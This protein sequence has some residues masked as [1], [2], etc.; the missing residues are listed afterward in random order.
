MPCEP[1]DEERQPGFF[2]GVT[3]IKKD[4]LEPTSPAPG[5][6]PG[7]PRASPHG[8]NGP[9]SDMVPSDCPVCGTLQGVET[10]F[11]KHGSSY[12]DR[13]LPEAAARL[14]IV[15]SLD[16]GDPEKRHVRR[17]P[18]CGALFSYLLAYDYYIDGS[19]D[20]ETLTRLSADGTAAFRRGEAL[21]LEAV[22]AEI[23]R[24]ESEAGRLGDYIDRGHP[25]PSEM[26]EAMT[27]MEESRAAAAAARKRLQA[28]VES[29]RR[30]CPEILSDWAGAHLRVVR[31]LLAAGFTET[32]DGSTARHIAGSI[33]EAWRALP[34][35]GDA[36]VS[37]D[38][39]FLP[40]YLDRL[41]MELKP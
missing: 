33:L 31:A 24:L 7:L 32:P 14:E 6:A 37:V 38:S 36:F 2:I 3:T 39:P 8:Y 13:P 28:Q 1:D 35:G 20:E 27:R 23:D 10:S 26:R 9:A 4:R 41:A 22:R 34:A 11:S 16:G 21:R 25:S 15:P 29:L 40:D 19:E 30:T 12:P 18:S 5:P 17:C